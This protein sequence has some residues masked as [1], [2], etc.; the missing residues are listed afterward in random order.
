MAIL[1]FM[2]Q[3]RGL[4]M[5]AIVIFLWSWINKTGAR[6]L[7]ELKIGSEGLISKKMGVA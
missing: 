2:F 1:I 4:R 7:R 3:N 6:L 5:A